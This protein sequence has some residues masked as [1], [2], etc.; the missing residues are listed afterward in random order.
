M[1]YYK[2][3]KRAREHKTSPQGRQQREHIMRQTITVA[4][5]DTVDF[6]V[7]TYGGF[8]A[9]INVVSGMRANAIVEISSNWQG[10]ITGRKIKIILRGQALAMALAI[11]HGLTDRDGDDYNM[12]DIIDQDWV[13]AYEY[14]Y[15]YTTIRKGF[16]V[17]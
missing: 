12:E 13:D 6:G 4:E 1:L 2:C 3:S 14:D 11:Y 9:K 15:D 8:E 5:I 16:R 17:E 7:G 10:S